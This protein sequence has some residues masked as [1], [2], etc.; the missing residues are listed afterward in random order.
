MKTVMNQAAQGDML[1]RRVDSLPEGAKPIASEQGMFVLAHSETG[2]NHCVLERPG[3][4]FFSG[5]ELLKS[6]LVVPEGEEVEVFH[7]RDEHT[8]ESLK[9]PAGT[10]EITRQREYDVTEGWRLAAD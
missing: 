10:W 9:L 3:V 4:Q 2:H 6:F 8:H 1:L 5:M 7:L